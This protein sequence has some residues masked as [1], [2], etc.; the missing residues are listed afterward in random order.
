MKKSDLRVTKTNRTIRE[1]FL[2]QICVKPVNKITVA[3]LVQEAEISKGTFYLHYTDIYALYDALLV[4]IVGGIVDRTD[5]YPYLF[6]NPDEFVRIFLYAETPP[7]R[8]DEI[9]MLNAENLRFSAKYPRVFIDAFQQKI[10][11]VGKLAPS[12][13]NDLR[14]E[15]LLNGLL[16]LLIK[17][18]LLS[19]G[20]PAGAPYVINLFAG[21]IRQLFSEFYP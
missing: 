11:D 10:Y 9:A 5:P 6:S 2:K 4:E 16:S 19:I 3:G 8:R 21:N 14:L 17:P 13:E 1:T 15:Y 20:N 12:Q 18:G 7:P